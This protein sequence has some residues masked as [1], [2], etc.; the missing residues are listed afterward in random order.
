LDEAVRL[1]PD[2]AE[3]W[4]YRALVVEHEHGYPAAAPDYRTASR[5]APGMKEVWR[6]HAEALLNAG[7]PALAEAYYL[8]AIALDRDYGEAW[9]MLGRLY[10]KRGDLE[11]AVRM[12]ERDAVLEPQGSAHHELGEVLLALGDD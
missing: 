5:L 4:L 9:Y 1:R 7:E 6:H 3:A 2:S 12:F 8:M 10:R 11:R